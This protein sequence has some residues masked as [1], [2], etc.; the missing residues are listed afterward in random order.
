MSTPSARTVSLARGTRGGARSRRRTGRREKGSRLLQ[1][2]GRRE[3]ASSTIWRGLVSLLLWILYI[4]LHVDDWG[5]FSGHPLDLLSTTALALIGW[6][7]YARR[8]GGF[9]A[10]YYANARF[11][12]PIERSAEPVDA[13]FTRVD[14]GLRFGTDDEPDLP[15][16]FFNDLKF[17]YYRPGDP[18]R[19]SL[20]FSAIWHGYWRAISWAPQELYLRSVEYVRTEPR[21]FAIG[22]WHKL[23]YTLGW[24]GALHPDAATAWFYVVVWMLGVTGAIAL[25]RL[26]PQLSLA[27]SYLPLLIA[28]THLA[29]CVI[30]W[31]DVY[32][33]RM[34]LPIYLLLVPYAACSFVVIDRA[35]AR[36]RSD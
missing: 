14:S 28:A 7:A 5:L 31:P 30:F 4:V 27:A 21:A 12:D 35:I 1:T 6:M 10:R 9:D 15:L 22:L 32:V 26:Q 8:S 17:N 18:D 3:H 13:T 24:F 29:V 34:I 36:T 20:R 2:V 11:A 25:W 33:D 19:R 16:Y 23:Q